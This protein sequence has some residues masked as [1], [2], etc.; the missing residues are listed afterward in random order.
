MRLWD[1]LGLLVAAYTAY[2]AFNGRV[3]ARHRA[4]GREIRRDEEPRYFWVV[5]CCYA[6]LATALVFL[7]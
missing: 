2:A 4:W 7:F 5:I 6:L 3:Y 1:V